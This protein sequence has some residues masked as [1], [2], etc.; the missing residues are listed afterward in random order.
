[1]NFFFFFHKSFFARHEN[2]E[3]YERNISQEDTVW[4]NEAKEL[5]WLEL[6][7]WFAGKNLICQDN[8]I[9]RERTTLDNCK[10]LVCAYKFVPL[11]HNSFNHQTSLESDIFYDA[12]VS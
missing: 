9:H 11:L 1:M 8:W 5:I 4:Q 7:A 10:K 2:G 3:A 12:Q 6:Q